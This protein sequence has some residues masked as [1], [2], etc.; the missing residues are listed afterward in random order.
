[1]KPLRPYSV[2]TPVSWQ[3]GARMAH[4]VIKSVH[5]TST[6]ITSK[7]TQVTRNA[8]P[9]KPAYIIVQPDKARKILKSHTEIMETL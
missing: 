8:T 7:G 9:E 4:G 3:W 5:T 6:T 2:G 1:M